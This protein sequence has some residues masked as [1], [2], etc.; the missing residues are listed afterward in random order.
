M[1]GG[2]AIAIAPCFMCGRSFAFD[3]DRVAS[4]RIDPVTGNAPDLGGDPARARRE[5]LCPP[6]CR[7][8]NRERAARGLELLDETDSAAELIR[9]A[10]QP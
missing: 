6:C 9:E 1:T 2:A 3:P 10:R 5:P 7:L 4:I 8:A